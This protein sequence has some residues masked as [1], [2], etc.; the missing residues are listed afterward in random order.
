MMSMKITESSGNV[1]ADL[2][3]PPEKAESLRLRTLL[4]IEIVKYIDREDITQA[5]AATRMGAKQS[6]ISEI[7]RGTARGRTTLN[8]R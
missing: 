6:R 8:G 4:T 1:F 2:G 7:K 5:E 3:F